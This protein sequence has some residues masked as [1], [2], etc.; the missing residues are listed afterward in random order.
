[1]SYI[2]GNISYGKQPKPTFGGNGLGMGLRGNYPGTC[3]LIEN[4]YLCLSIIHGSAKNLDPV[5]DFEYDLT[6]AHIT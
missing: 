2:K 3:C 1:M 5:C 6:F 4:S